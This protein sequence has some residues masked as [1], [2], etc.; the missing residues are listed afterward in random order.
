MRNVLLI[1][2]REYLEQLR[3]R[4]FKISTVMM[5]LLI[6]ALLTFSHYMDKKANTGRHIAIVAQDAALANEVRAQ[7]LDDKDAQYTVDV[8]APATEEQRAEWQRQVRDKKI[9]GV[10]SID[11]SNPEKITATF[12]SLSVAEVAAE[13]SL[14]NALNRGVINERLIAKG[15]TQA[16]ADATLEKVSI[17]ALQLDKDGNIGKSNGKVK[18]IKATLM[19][20]AVDAHHAVRAGHGAGDHRG[21]DVAHFRGD[22]GDCQARETFWRANCWEWARSGLTQIAIWLICATIFMGSAWR[23]KC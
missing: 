7:M 17:D 13:G 8:T 20:S 23:R 5:P 15:M 22:A 12:V 1:A 18:V 4:A 6:A 21:E 11:T 19:L 9:D 3:G 10:L 2:K 16:G 14:Q